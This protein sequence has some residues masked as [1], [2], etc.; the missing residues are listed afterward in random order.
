MN[1]TDAQEARFWAKVDKTD[2]CWLWQG[3]RQATGHG[4]MRVPGDPT[5]WIA[6]HRMAWFLT[7]GSLPLG[8][9]D[10]AVCDNPPCVNPSHLEDTTQQRNIQRAYDR[11]ASFACG[12]SWVPE[13]T[14]YEGRN[15]TYRRCKTCRTKQRHASYMRRIER[16]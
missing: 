9:L 2:T 8:V 7:N 14:E 6:A 12:H 1:V 4:R 5:R 10:H 13:N 11:R 3:A 15:K 16:M